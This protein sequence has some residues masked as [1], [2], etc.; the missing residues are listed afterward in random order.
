MSPTT[1]SLIAFMAGGSLTL[2]AGLLLRDLVW[3]GRGQTS[4]VRKSGL[5]RHRDV[6]DASPARTLTER[7]DQSFDR[8]IIES[9]ST[10]A[11][12]QAPLALL[13][14]S[15]IVGGIGWLATDEP[16]T[17]VVLAAAS[18]MLMLAVWIVQRARRLR[19]VR[20]Q[21]PHVVDL[22]ARATRAGRSI[23][24][25][26]SLV[27]SEAGGI[28]GEEFARCEQQLQVGRSFDKALQS[29]ARRVSL[30]ELQLLATT[31]I[32]QR[33]SGGHL[34]ETLDRMVEVIRDRLNAQRQIRASTAAGRMST[35]VVA[36]IT[37]LA[38]LFLFGFQRDHLQMLFD[39][40]LGRTLLMTALVLEIIG[41]TWVTWLLRSEE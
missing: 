17:G 39:D 24:Q 41:L 16:L 5:R 20:E 18:L 27:A 14:V 25:S 12:S 10:L 3:A 4:R 7:V 36:S 9:G 32:V 21:L 13:A 38:L 11:P 26:F 22:L 6:F 30:V 33:Q 1:I 34:S 40:A 8:L 37:P 28:L 35:V 29:L 2:A 23:E 19:A 31:L 15:L